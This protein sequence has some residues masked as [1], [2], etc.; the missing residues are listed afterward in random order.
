MLHPETFNYLQP[1]Q[2]QINRM[3]TVR[4]RFAKFA[5]ELESL[6]PDGPDRTY[7]MRQLREVAMWANVTITRLPDG[8]PRHD[9]ES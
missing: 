2:A 3:Q 1:T 9:G 5:F 8:T 6:L 7:I 4:D